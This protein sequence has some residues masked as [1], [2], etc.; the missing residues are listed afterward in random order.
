MIRPT[1]VLFGLLVL[2]APAVRADDEEASMVQSVEV[3]VTAV[4]GG[5][6][7]LDKGRRAHI[8]AGDRVSLHPVG[9]LPLEVVVRSVSSK[10][11][12]ADLPTALA[13]S[14]AFITLTSLQ[15]RAHAPPRIPTG[16]SRPRAPKH[17]PP[18]PDPGRDLA[19]NFNS[20]LTIAPPPCPDLPG[21]PRILH[22]LEAHPLHVPHH[23][24][25][26]PRRCHLL[27]GDDARVQ[28]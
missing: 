8:E 11:S 26:P 13:V 14:G 15:V 19:R 21:L 24:S 10:S 25:L 16:A 9:G 23:V 28:G 4:A 22:R 1:C 12:R 6:I 2:A 18:C 27:R 7:Y 5:S 20:A 17:T 3:K